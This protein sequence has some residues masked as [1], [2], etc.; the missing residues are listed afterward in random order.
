MDTFPT[1][2]KVLQWDREILP[3]L[4]QP[5]QPVCFRKETGHNGGRS[6]RGDNIQTSADNAQKPEESDPHYL[7]CRLCRQRI[8]TTADRMIVN[9]AHHHT[10][11]NPGGFVFDV[12]CFQSAP[13]CGHSGAKTDEFTWFP[14]YKW[15]IA[16]CSG[17][18][19]HMGWRFTASGNGFH[20]LILDHLISTKQDDHT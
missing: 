11:A 4:L 2:S 19:L 10:F 15:Q 7:L 16:V 18:L 12:G 13:G 1:K 17:C 9:N 20:A 3:A 5:I 8:T 6:S 14:G